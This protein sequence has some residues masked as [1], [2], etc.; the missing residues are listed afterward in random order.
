MPGHKRFFIVRSYVVQIFHNEQTLNCFADL[1]NAGQYAI[2]KYVFIDPRIAFYLGFV[3]TNSVQKEN[4]VIFKTSVDSLHE[5]FVVFT[6]D[7]FEHSD[8]YYLIK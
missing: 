3:T 2:G 8:G 4:A 6:A 1:R 5:G 7:V